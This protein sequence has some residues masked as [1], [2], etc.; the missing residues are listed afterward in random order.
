[1]TSKDKISIVLA[2]TVCLGCSFS[3][4]DD[5]HINA[6][7]DRTKFSLSKGWKKLIQVKPIEKNKLYGEWEILT[8]LFTFTLNDGSKGNTTFG[9]EGNRLKIEEN[10]KLTSSSPSHT[11]SGEWSLTNESTVFNKIFDDEIFDSFQVRVVGD[12]M[13]WINPA[14][15]D[16]LI[17]FVLV[18]K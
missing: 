9:M 5:E 6:I 10:G 11:K 8:S 15:D 3:T 7:T 16:D 14:G 17:Y 18:K 4:V 1:M 2:L 12:T 13:E